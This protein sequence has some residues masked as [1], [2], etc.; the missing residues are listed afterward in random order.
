MVGHYTE[1]CP[2]TVGELERKEW[3]TGRVSLLWAGLQTTLEVVLQHM[4]PSGLLLGKAQRII[5]EQGSG[6]MFRFM[7]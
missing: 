2:R 5:D 3:G 7:G 6:F 4:Q 1:L